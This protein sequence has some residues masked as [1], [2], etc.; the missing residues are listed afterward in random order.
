[1]MRRVVAQSALMLLL[2]GGG[3]K[4]STAEARHVVTNTE[5]A[6]DLLIRNDKLWVASRGGVEVYSLNDNKRIKVF[7]TEDGLAQNHI[8]QIRSESGTIKARTA[9]HLCSLSERQWVC[10]DAEPWAITPAR[11]KRHNGFRITAE[12]SHK[13][14]SYLA[15]AGDGVRKLGSD[16]TERR[17]TPKGQICSNHISAIAKFEGRT[18]FGSFDEGLCSTEDGKKFTTH[19]FGA[20]MINDLEVTPKGL[21]V[22]A[23]AGL[24]LLRPNSDLLE[25]S[26]SESDACRSLVGD[27]VRNTWVSQ[28][29]VN[30]L[31]FDGRSLYVTT[32]GCL[33][34]VR[35]QGGPRDKE[36]W[37]PGGSRSLQSVATAGTD[38]W[39]ATEDRGLVRK[40]GNRFDVFDKA[41]GA[42]ESWFLDVTT[43]RRGNAYGATLRSGV[44]QVG[45]DGRVKQVMPKA[46][47]WGLF[48]GT[49]QGELWLGSQ[50]GAA[51]RKGKQTTL[52]SDVPHPN[53]HVVTRL[54]DKLY[55]GTEGGLL[56]D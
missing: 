46:N 22:A 49:T 30:G 43:D 32:K 9:K 28:P 51:K 4:C 2:C 1:M 39:I 21:F 56:V 37:M 7:T 48:V 5:H 42:P 15:L 55:I 34:R 6:E 3:G 41:A 44:V 13:G 52:H 38:V 36:W 20:R 45:K 53:V 50:G 23:G 8:L 19:E 29:G 17:L 26:T 47:P 24:F 31:A 27:F 16:K 12:V 18:W 33:W 40:K 11:Q 14:S 35:V 25:C 10:Q 54:N